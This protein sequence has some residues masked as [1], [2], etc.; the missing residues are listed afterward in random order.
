M[1]LNVFNLNF[2]I[3]YHHIPYFSTLLPESCF[4]ILLGIVL[5]CFSF[6]GLKVSP[7]DEQFPVFTAELFFNVLL[8]P[9]IL[10]SAFSLYDRQS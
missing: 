6:L 10:D 3:T 2:Q 1:H 9:I 7:C 4:L 8:P 5:A